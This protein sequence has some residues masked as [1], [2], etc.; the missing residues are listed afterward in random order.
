MNGW[1]LLTGMYA[2]QRERRTLGGAV[3]PNL[4][5]VGYGG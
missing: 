2:M 3:G 5:G 1:H 4:E